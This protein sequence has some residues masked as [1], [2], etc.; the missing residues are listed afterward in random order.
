MGN[1]S[2]RLPV[3]VHIAHDLG[4]YTKSWP[5][6]L[7][8]T[9]RGQTRVPRS[10]QGSNDIVAIRRRINKLAAMLQANLVTGSV[11][12]RVKEKRRSM[13]V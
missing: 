11:G 10:R 5:S 2:P 1:N 6:P 7:F 8:A 4:T 9:A 13:R 12:M 3:A